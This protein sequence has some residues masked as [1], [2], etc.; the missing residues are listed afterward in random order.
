[1]IF[2]AFEWIS[3]IRP[4]PFTTL[5][6]FLGYVFGETKYTL[7]YQVIDILHVHP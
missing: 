5:G 1:M 3:L 6:I 4:A 7:F 2:R